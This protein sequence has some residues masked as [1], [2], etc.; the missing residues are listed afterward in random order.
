M[1]HYIKGKSSKNFK[2]KHV[3]LIPKEERYV[4]K[5]VF[6]PIISE[7]TFRLAQSLFV[8]NKKNSG[9]TNPYAG[10]VFCGICGKPLSIQRHKGGSGHY[11][12]RL[13][14]RNTNE[15]GKGTILLEDLNEV[16]KKELFTLKN[17]LLK[18]KTIFLDFVINRIEELESKQLTN[19]Y[20][21]RLINIDKRLKELNKYIQN[22]FE[23]SI[24]QALP[25]DT[26]NKF[27]QEYLFEKKTLEMEYNKYL[28]LS[29]ID[30]D[31]TE[32]KLNKFLSKL[33]NMDEDNFTSAVI[34]RNLISKILITT[35]DSGTSKLGKQVTIYYKCCDSAIKEFI[36]GDN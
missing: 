33:D 26:Y 25:A 9:I 6:D 7:E 17:V 13:V 20:S 11:E 1:G 15:I 2:T 10:L 35:F 30:N 36:E 8:G 12:E 29:N 28:L 23:E 34:I 24:N 5:N 18:N 31:N 22:L 14:C 16:I 27:M 4:F 3:I 21:I 19:E 32:T